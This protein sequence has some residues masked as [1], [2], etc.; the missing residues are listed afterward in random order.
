L[1]PNVPNRF[2]HRWID[3]KTE[4]V[5]NQVPRRLGRLVLIGR[6]NASGLTRC[7]GAASGSCITASKKSKGS[8]RPPLGGSPAMV[9][10]VPAFAVSRMPFSGLLEMSASPGTGETSSRCGL[11]KVGSPALGFTG[12]RRRPRISIGCGRKPLA[13]HEPGGAAAAAISVR[14]VLFATL[15]FCAPGRTSGLTTR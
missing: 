1:S 8:S 11:E 13:E 3:L 6:R 15:L 5:L 14:H 4:F 7:R 12:V 2:C 9:K 10:L